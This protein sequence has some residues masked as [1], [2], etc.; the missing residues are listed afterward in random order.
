MLRTR[1]LPAIFE[2][3]L[4]S[5][6]VKTSTITVTVNFTRYVTFCTNL[7]N[8]DKTLHLQQPVALGDEYNNCLQSEK[9]NYEL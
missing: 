5:F 3:N 8:E 2:D 6:F 1:I 9:G 7:L 4:Q